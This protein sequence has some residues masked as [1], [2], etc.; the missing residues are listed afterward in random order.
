MFRKIELTPFEKVSAF[1]SIQVAISGIRDKIRS[2]TSNDQIVEQKK[3]ILNGVLTKCMG[4]IAQ[5]NRACLSTESLIALN[6]LNLFNDLLLIFL[7]IKES[8]I[9][10]LCRDRSLLTAS[11]K[12]AT[13]AT[14]LIGCSIAGAVFGGP[15]GFVAA[16][17]VGHKAG[18][19]GINLKTTDSANHLFNLINATA[20]GMKTFSKTH[21]IDLKT[22]RKTPDIAWDDQNTL[23]TPLDWETTLLLSLK[24]R[25]LKCT[26]LQHDKEVTLDVNPYLEE[27]EIALIREFKVNG[28]SQKTELL[29]KLACMRARTT[30]KIADTLASEEVLSLAPS[31]APN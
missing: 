20:D 21:G 28:E 6:Q 14:S 19:A 9:E 15:M 30:Q 27:G 24:G 4:K 16:G 25:E 17:Y 31:T 23:E 3:A 8:D 10:I 1:E 11:T 18:Q 22:E 5:Y 29:I 7:R 2:L 13:Y 12:F 26:F